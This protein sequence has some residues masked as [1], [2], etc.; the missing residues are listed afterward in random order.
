MDIIPDNFWNEIKDLI[1][2]K[3]T[4]VGRPELSP[5]KALNAI[6]YIIRTEIQW[7]L[8][9]REFGNPSTIHGKFRKWIKEGFFE[10]IQQMVLKIYL[11]K[12]A[13]NWAA[14]DTSSSKS[15]FASGWG[16]KKPYR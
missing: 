5:R 10:K 14:T 16:E 2:H 15:P 4:A 7:W 1:P 8:L 13:L 3:N 12:N 9:P 11:Q 6:F